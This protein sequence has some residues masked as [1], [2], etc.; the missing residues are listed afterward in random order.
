MILSEGSHLK[1]FQFEK[2]LF[3]CLLVIG[4]TTADSYFRR[5]CFLPEQPRVSSEEGTE[6]LPAADLELPVIDK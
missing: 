6:S 4:Y 1:K 2:H 3:S 5:L